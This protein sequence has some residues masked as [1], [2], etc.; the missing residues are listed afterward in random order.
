MGDR[1]EL[2]FDK[3]GGFCCFYNTILWIDRYILD[4]SKKDPVIFL[5]TPS[6]L[7]NG[8]SIKNLIILTSDPYS[9]Y[10]KRNHKDRKNCIESYIKNIYEAIYPNKVLVHL[11]VLMPEG[12]KENT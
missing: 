2:F 1:E 12:I 8:S 6:R 11:F 9:E 4:T 10:P 7:L 5:K 3:L